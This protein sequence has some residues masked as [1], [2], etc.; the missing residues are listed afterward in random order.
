MNDELEWYWK[1]SNMDCFK[2]AFQFLPDVTEEKPENF[3]YDSRS[4]G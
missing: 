4:S 3:G 1:E 2:E